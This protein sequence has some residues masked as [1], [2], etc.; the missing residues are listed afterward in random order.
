MKTN[1]PVRDQRL[2]WC[3][4]G[5]NSPLPPLGSY[6]NILGW[7]CGLV[8]E[9]GSEWGKVL[10]LDRFSA[11]GRQDM[12]Q[13]NATRVVATG[14]KKVSSGGH[15]QPAFQGHLREALRHTPRTGPLVYILPA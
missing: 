11:H 10:P 1:G 3:V 9:V 13:V 6:K 12:D 7:V 2:D 14:H 4:D 5:I 8:H 15:H